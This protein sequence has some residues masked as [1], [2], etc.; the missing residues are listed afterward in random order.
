[1]NTTDL[2]WGRENRHQRGGDYQR[3]NTIHLLSAEEQ[4]LDQ[5]GVR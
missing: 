2:R 5:R 4:R 1:M 3:M